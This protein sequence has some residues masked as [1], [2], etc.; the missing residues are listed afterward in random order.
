[1]APAARRYRVVF[2][3]AFWAEDLNRLSADGRRHATD[4]R[5]NVEAYGVSID[6]TLPCR[7]EGQDGTR[8]P[9]C[10]KRYIPAAASDPYRIVLAPVRVDGVLVFLCMAFGLGHPSERSNVPSAYRLAHFR[11]HGERL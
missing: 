4:A 9:G 6:D 5:E 7:P 11:I 3:D 2:N 8:L 10:R 1:M